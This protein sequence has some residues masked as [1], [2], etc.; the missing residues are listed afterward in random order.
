MIAKSHS[1]LKR[2]S[3]FLR[4]YENPM[5]WPSSKKKEEIDRFGS[6]SVCGR[7]GRSDVNRVQLHW[8]YLIRSWRSMN[9]S[10]QHQCMSPILTVHWN[11]I[12][13]F[14]IIVCINHDGI[15]N[16]WDLIL[17]KIVCCATKREILSSALSAVCFEFKR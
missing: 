9:L 2:Y 17:F 1:F 3:F 8:I 6:L 4:H 15:W 11:K 14:V 12:C 16:C 7:C 5:H 10:I 13:K